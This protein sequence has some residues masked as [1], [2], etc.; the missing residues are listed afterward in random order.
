MKIVLKICTYLLVPK[1]GEQVCSSDQENELKKPNGETDFL[2]PVTPL[3]HS[4]TLHFESVG[5]M[6]RGLHALGF[7]LPV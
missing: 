4:Q 2:F 7:K 1:P 6:G 3:S 5:L